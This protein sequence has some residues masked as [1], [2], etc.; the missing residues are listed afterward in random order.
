V[1]AKLGGAAHIKAS[2]PAIGEKLV[3][4]TNLIESLE[5]VRVRCHAKMLLQ[6]AEQKRAMHESMGNL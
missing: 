1:E 4:M 5:K 3:Q 6:K 2:R